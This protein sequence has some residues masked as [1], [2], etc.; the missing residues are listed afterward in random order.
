MEPTTLEEAVQVAK[1]V[2]DWEV[3]KQKQNVMEERRTLRPYD[4]AMNWSLT[5]PIIKSCPPNSYVE[6]THNRHPNSIREEE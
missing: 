2:D 1:H 4:R 5:N 6:A 3:V